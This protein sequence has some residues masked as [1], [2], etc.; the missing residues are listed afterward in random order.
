MQETWIRS[1]GQVDPWRGRWQLAPVFLPGKSYRQRCLAD[2]SLWG[3]KELHILEHEHAPSLTLKP[4]TYLLD[5][6]VCKW[7][8]NPAVCYPCLVQP[9]I[10]GSGC[11]LHSDWLPCLSL[12]NGM[13]E[14]EMDGWHH[15]LDGHEFE[16]SPGVGDGQGGLA[17]CDSWG[18][19]VGHDRATELNW[20]EWLF[21]EERKVDRQYIYIY[22]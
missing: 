18:R 21:K 16:W 19:R 2:Y 17:C 15:R 8:F 1:L 6:P 10:P 11:F 20:T 14:D 22:I 12:S 3:H 9:T 13:T 7:F 5:L 4:F